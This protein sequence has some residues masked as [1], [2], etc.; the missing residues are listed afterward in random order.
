VEPLT[1]PTEEKEAFQQ[2]SLVEAAFQSLK[3]ALCTAI[4]LLKPIIYKS[5]GRFYAK[6][7]V[8]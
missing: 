6:E 7:Q 1:R 2:S 4:L 8:T 5:Q 3:E